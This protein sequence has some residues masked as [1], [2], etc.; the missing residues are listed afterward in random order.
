MEGKRILVKVPD[1]KTNKILLYHSTNSC[2]FTLLNL[3]EIIL[4]GPDQT[5]KRKE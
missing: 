2:L 4:A 3:Q 1:C 5:N